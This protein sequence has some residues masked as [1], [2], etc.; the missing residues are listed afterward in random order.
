MAIS[1]N[2]LSPEADKDRHMRVAISLAPLPLP[3]AFAVAHAMARHPDLV[4]S[5]RLSR[6]AWSAAA[7]AALLRRDRAGLEILLR[8]ELAPAIAG[9]TAML[10][11]AT[12]T[13]WPDEISEQWLIEMVAR[14]DRTCVEVLHATEVVRVA[15]L[16]EALIN[17][18][19]APPTRPEP[20]AAVRL[21]ERA[22]GYLQTDQQ[23]DTVIAVFGDLSDALRDLASPADALVKAV[24]DDRLDKLLTHPLQRQLYR[25]YAVGAAVLAYDLALLGEGPLVDPQTTLVMPE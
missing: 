23:E 3:E 24:D 21:L 22:A 14:L 7:T 17:P 16:Y 13:S 15:E 8:I 2:A 1:C 5:H 18:E 25:A 12:A 11:W 9:A 19:R 6:R 10:G 4:A 20:E